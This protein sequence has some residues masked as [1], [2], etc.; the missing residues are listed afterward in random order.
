MIEWEYFFDWLVDIEMC[1][2]DTDI[3]IAFIC[4]IGQLHVAYSVHIMCFVDTCMY[5]LIDENVQISIQISL[6]FVAK[7]PITN[8][9]ALF[10]I[11]AWRRPAD[12]P[13][14]EL[15]MA[16]FTDTYMRHSP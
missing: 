13:V 8:I 11:M 15:M 7:G 3:S 14:S 16:R 1:N 10:Q 2:G 5:L 9:Q 4:I 6:K 12:N